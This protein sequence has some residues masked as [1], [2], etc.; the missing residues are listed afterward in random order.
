METLKQ[1]A[2]RISGDF[3]PLAT[4]NNNFFVNDIPGDM[5]VEHNRDSVVSIINGMLS[6][7]LSHARNTCIRLSAKTYGYVMVLEVHEAGTVN[8]YALACALQDIQSHAQRIGGCLDI[9]IPRPETTTI[10]FSFPN[11]PIAA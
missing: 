1:L 8:S 7:I 5:A 2:G 3:L 4:S 10:A 9:L 11:L 6:T